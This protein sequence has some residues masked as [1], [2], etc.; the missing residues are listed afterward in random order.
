MGY[1]IKMLN[2]VNSGTSHR[3]DRD[4]GCANQNPFHQMRKPTLSFKD[5][6][7]FYCAHVHIQ[8]NFFILGGMNIT[9]SRGRC[10]FTKY[11]L[12]L[13]HRRNF[14]R[15]SFILARKYGLDV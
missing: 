10:C 7:E 1:R 12:S 4:E 15:R 2:K 5:F 9:K 13:L 11:V 3:K 8:D 6:A 14:R